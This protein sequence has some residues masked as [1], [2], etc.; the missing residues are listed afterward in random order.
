VS[1]MTALAWRVHREGL[2]YLFIPVG[3]FGAVVAL[4]FGVSSSGQVNGAQELAQF[5]ERYGTHGSVVPVGIGL[6]FGPGFVA[7]F[8]AISAAML[9]RN[10]IGSETSRGGIELLLAAPYRPRTIMTALL[11]YTAVVT[12]VY[13]LLMSGLIAVAVA[14]V[15]AADGASVT[16]TASYL[17]AALPVPL[18]VGW[19]AAALALAVNLLYPR[20]AQMGGY[21]IHV[22]GGGISGLPALLPGLAVFLTFVLWAPHVSAL[23]LLVIVGGATAALTILSVVT[24]TIRFR[25]DAVLES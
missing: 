14:V 3:I 22:S 7:L 9:V 19:A 2:R 23:A 8:T 1:L 18:L 10:L 16:L 4:V 20:L 6:L 25:P 11:G 24:V 5:A 13:W 15:C 21:G 12:T 17:V